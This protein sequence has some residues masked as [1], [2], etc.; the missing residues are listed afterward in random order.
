MAK[1]KSRNDKVELVSDELAQNV[2][3]QIL[4]G[5]ECLVHQKDAN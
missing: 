4:K 2:K 5:A 1:V 3:G